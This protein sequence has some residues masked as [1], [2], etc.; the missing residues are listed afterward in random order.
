MMDINKLEPAHIV[1]FDG[2]SIQKSRYWDIPKRR[3]PY[4]TKRL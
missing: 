1:I 3:Y 4:P 2:K